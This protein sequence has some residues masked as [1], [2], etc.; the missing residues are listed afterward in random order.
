MGLFG[1]QVHHPMS[2]TKLIND[3]DTGLEISLFSMGLHIVKHDLMDIGNGVIK[4]AFVWVIF[5]QL[6]K[7]DIFSEVLHEFSTC[8]VIRY[9]DGYN[10][11]FLTK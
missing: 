2:F 4:L 3:I 7:A 1:S 8:V 11:S 9:C 5:M 10:I 6:N